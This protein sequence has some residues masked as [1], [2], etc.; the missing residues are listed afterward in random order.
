MM[1]DHTAV[2]SGAQLRYRHGMDELGDDLLLL[3]ARSDGT[4]ALPAKLRFG[5]A[6]SE[7][8]RLAAAR[9][10]DI[11]RGRIVILDAAPTGDQL[12]DEA[13]ASM[14]GRRREPTA[15]AWV[16]RNRPGLVDRYLARAEAAG[17]IRSDRRTMLGFIPMTRWLVLDTARAAQARARLAAVAESTGP[18]DTAQAAL[19]GLASAI[20]VARVVFPG[21]AGVATRKRLRQAARREPTAA[22]V[23]TAVTGAGDAG[24]QAADAATRAAMEAA[25]RAATDAAVSAAVDAATQATISAADSTGHHG[26]HGGALGGHH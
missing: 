9:R 22:G 1:L 4:L 14:T 7:L 18:V 2:A 25:V 23:T 8:V 19:A 15:K 5:L 20:D 21:L 17:L 24:T 12:L 6:G 11:A 3:A 26:G 10:I 16:A 13:L